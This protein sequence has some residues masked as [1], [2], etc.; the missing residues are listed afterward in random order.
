LRD[1]RSERRRAKA[2]HGRDARGRCGHPA[3]R[4]TEVLNGRRFT[5]RHL[6]GCRARS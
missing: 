3:A 4:Q 1:R 6:D 2:C 5:G